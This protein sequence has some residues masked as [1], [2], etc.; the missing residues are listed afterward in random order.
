MFV[1]FKTKC[2]TSMLSNIRLRTALF[3]HNICISN[4]Q[5]HEPSN[6]KSKAL[7]TNLAHA[8]H[9]QLTHCQ[10]RGSPSTAC[11]LQTP[12]GWIIFSFQFNFLLSC[13]Y[14]FFVVSTISDEI[15]KNMGAIWWST[16]ISVS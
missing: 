9:P 16:V 2:E 6:L 12:T 4:W 13:V 15:F 7:K 5:L 11:G 3:L 1:S 8:T 14:L 10:K